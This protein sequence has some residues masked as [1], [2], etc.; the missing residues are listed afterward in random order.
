MWRS[1]TRGVTRD[2]AVKQGSECVLDN[3]GVAAVAEK[4]EFVDA[5]VH[6][7][8]QLGWHQPTGIRIRVS[9]QRGLSKAPV[10]VLVASTSVVPAWCLLFGFNLRAVAF[11]PLRESFTVAVGQHPGRFPL[12]LSVAWSSRAWW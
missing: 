5:G 9:T 1:V 2:Q 10:F 12:E 8:E 4:P 3:D 6:G 7:S 11:A